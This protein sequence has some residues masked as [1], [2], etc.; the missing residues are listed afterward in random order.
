MISYLF[1]SKGA[2]PSRAISIRQAN[3]KSFEQELKTEK[4]KNVDLKQRAESVRSSQE[5]PEKRGEL[6]E[7]LEQLTLMKKKLQ[8]ELAVYKENDPEI[9]KTHRNDIKLAKAACNRWIENM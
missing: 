4:E 9:V 1:F 8:N 5:E 6:L 7:K 3:I 2:L